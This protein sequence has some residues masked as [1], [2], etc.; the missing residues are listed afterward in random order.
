MINPN[1]TI[2]EINITVS[3]VLVFVLLGESLN[4]FQI[5]TPYAAATIVAPFRTDE[6][7]E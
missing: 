4:S 7:A 5:K 6:W 1:P 3:K 2:K